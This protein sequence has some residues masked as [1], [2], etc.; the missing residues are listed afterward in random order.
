MFVGVGGTQR[1]QTFVH[2]IVLQVQRELPEHLSEY[3]SEHLSAAVA[4]LV[5]VAVVEVVQREGMVDNYKVWLQWEVADHQHRA[6]KD[7]QD[8]FAAVLH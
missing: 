5:V 4:T 6:L 1:K 7:N 8:K 2:Q 3:L